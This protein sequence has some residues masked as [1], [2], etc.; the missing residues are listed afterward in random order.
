M[1]KIVKQRVFFLGENTIIK[2]MLGTVENKKQ[3][4]RFDFN[5]IVPMPENVYSGPLNGE[6]LAEYGENNWYDWCKQNWGTMNNAC[7]PSFGG[8]M[9]ELS[10]VC[11][12]PRPIYKA[13]SS[14]YPEIQIKV[15]YASKDRSSIG[16][17]LYK[18]GRFE[19]VD[20]KLDEHE[21]WHSLWGE[22]AANQYG[23]SDGG[24]TDATSA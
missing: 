22:T 20:S 5:K 18:N 3:H 8:N 11:G 13:L 19:K 17:E 2:E 12:L 7:D 9:M 15:V 23:Q 21:I 1:E 4:R 16:V 24:I 14:Q 6:A 10:T